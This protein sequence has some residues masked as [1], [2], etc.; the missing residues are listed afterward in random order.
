M[1]NMR[2]GRFPSASTKDDLDHTEAKNICVH[3]TVTRPETQLSSRDLDAS[4]ELDD[5][6]ILSWAWKNHSHVHRQ[7]WERGG[8]LDGEALIHR[9][10]HKIVHLQQEWYTDVPQ[11]APC[12]NLLRHD[13]LYPLI[14]LSK[15]ERLHVIPSH[16][17]N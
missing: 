7:I 13:I 9:H 6:T 8:K 16:R 2:E 5:T 14:D 17:M 3:T 1:I 12:S 10:H 4:R 11:I 15:R